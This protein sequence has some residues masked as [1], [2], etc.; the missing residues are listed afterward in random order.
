MTLL[1]SRSGGRKGQTQ[2]GFETFSYTSQSTR[3]THH[4]GVVPSFGYN[5]TCSGSTGL[6]RSR[7]HGVPWVTRS[8]FSKRD[9]T[10]RGRSEEVLWSEEVPRRDEEWGRRKTDTGPGGYTRGMFHGNGVSPSIHK[11]GV[12]LVLAAYRP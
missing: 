8:D 9:G 6:Q 2:E 5:Y 3:L 7:L 11:G 4:L 1:G 12:G 10:T